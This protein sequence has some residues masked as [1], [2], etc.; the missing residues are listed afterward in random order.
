MK[1]IGIGLLAWLALVTGLHFYWNVSFTELV[2]DRRPEDQRKLMLAYVP[3][4]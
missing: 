4:T 2:N 1:K 3:V